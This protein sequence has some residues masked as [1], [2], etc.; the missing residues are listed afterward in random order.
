MTL[1]ILF[2]CGTVE[3]DENEENS[4]VVVVSDVELVNSSWPLRYTTTESRASYEGNS[5]WISYFNRSYSQAIGEASG[6][7]QA[8]MHAEISAVYRQSA[9]LHAHATKHL[10]ESNA[11]PSDPKDA[12]YL[13][14]V[15][16]VML[17]ESDGVGLL[18]DHVSQNGPFT[19]QAQAW[20]E[21]A[22]GGSK[23]PTDL[24]VFSLQ[25][26]EPT[27]GTTMAVET[28]PH[29]QLQLQGDD[30]GTMDVSDTTSLWLRAVWHE[31][32]AK[33]ADSDSAAFVDAHLNS[34]RLPFE[35][36]ATSEFA[37]TGSDDWLFLSYAM[38][39]A[40]IKFLSAAKASGIASVGEFKAESIYAATLEGAVVDNKISVEQSLVLASRL[41]EQILAA[42][43]TKNGSLDPVH[44]IFA[45]Q[46]EIG[47][48]HAAML[49]ADS[50]DQYRDAGELR[51]NMRDMVQK[52]PKNPAYFLEL[53][54][55]D[56]G[57]KSPLRPQEIL[58]RFSDDFPALES[59]RIPLDSLHIR[60]SRGSGPGPLH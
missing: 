53:A 39:H 24:T 21:A 7:A 17:G 27:P 54:A 20:L 25:W 29:K 3:Q 8:R 5:S 50:N 33:M 1:F 32:S 49:V 13:L 2:G 57:N 15:A 59:A 26:Q 31:R 36:Q 46:A 9:R 30:G 4:P 11:Q 34:F 38:S 10:F 60:I 23:I 12:G 14:G 44:S 6:A 56:T 37:T 43:E 47:V 18:E 40:D 42:I 19:N 35:T 45:E 16:K 58:H 28:L 41:K 51:L 52:S 22:K 48:L 55:W